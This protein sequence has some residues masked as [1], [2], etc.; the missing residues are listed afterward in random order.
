MVIT[1]KYPS[2]HSTDPLIPLTLFLPEWKEPVPCSSAQQ[3]ADSSSSKTQVRSGTAS[4]EGGANLPL[5]SYSYH[6][7]H[8]HWRSVVDECKYEEQ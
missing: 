4:R 1:L 2:F 7:W 3:P 6:R 5:Q 8:V